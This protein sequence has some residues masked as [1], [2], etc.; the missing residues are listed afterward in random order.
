MTKKEAIVWLS[1]YREYEVPKHNLDW[2]IPADPSIITSGKEYIFSNSLI[3]TLIEEVNNSKYDPITTIAT[4]YYYWDE[5]LEKS[6]ISHK[7]T[8]AYASWM[9][10]ATHDI[11]WYLKK[12]EDEKWE[13]F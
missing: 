6:D 13:I 10:E 3:D 4:L 11:Y 8:H 5:I 2:R 9:E 7:T 12:R 1:V